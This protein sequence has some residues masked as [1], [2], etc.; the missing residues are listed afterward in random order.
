MGKHEWN[1]VRS[2]RVVLD[3][4][5]NYQ[6]WSDQKALAYW[7]TNIINQE[8]IAIREIN[9]MRHWPVQGITGKYGS[10]KLLDERRAKK[11]KGGFS[12]KEFHE[13]ILSRGGI[14]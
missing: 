3:V 4:G 2:V 12:L 9:R 10:A 11:L 13:E 5:L 8:D 14:F 7:K 6:G 1:L